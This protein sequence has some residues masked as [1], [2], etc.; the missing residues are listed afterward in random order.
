MIGRRQ[1]LLGLGRGVRWPD[2]VQRGPY[3]SRFILGDRRWLQR[4]GERRR[5]GGGWACVRVKEIC[6]SCV[7][8]ICIRHEAVL[9]QKICIRHEAVFL[10]RAAASDGYS[11][12]AAAVRDTLTV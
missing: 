2:L 12:C 1:R 10:P 9:L 5:V 8:V 7:T 4:K 3:G 11:A 6:D